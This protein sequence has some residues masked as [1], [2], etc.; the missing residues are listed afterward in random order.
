[1]AILSVTGAA[2]Q[3]GCYAYDDALTLKFASEENGTSINPIPYQVE[4]MLNIVRFTS[5]MHIY[6]MMFLLLVFAIVIFY[7]IV[8]SQKAFN[9]KVVFLKAVL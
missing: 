8:H 6:Y 2:G 7:M 5:L 3:Y 4:V 9:G 1:M